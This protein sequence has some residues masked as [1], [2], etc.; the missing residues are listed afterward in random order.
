MQNLDGE[1]PEEA[2]VYAPLLEARYK[3]IVQLIH[4]TG[5]DQVLELASGFSMRGLAM[6]AASGMTYLESDLP[7]I[8]EE[9]SKFVADLIAKHNLVGLDRHHIITANALNFSEFEAAIHILRRDRPLVVVNEGLLN[10]LSADERS[11]VA[12]NVRKLLS[13]FPGG[14]WITPDFTT[15]GVAENVSETAKR[16]RRA[17]SGITERQL[18]EAAFVDE[19]A[20][21]QFVRDSG[22]KPV[23]YYQADQVPF[24]SS[25][26]R[27]ELS[28]EIVIKMRPR[29]RTWLL[30]PQ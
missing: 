23:S 9:K 6:S 11:E 2:K 24:L 19:E 17:L 21:D 16:F 3:S 12:G 7:G 10:Y 1:L 30:S 22:F 8:S 18:N 20:I 15:R 25:L 27:L 28:P 13:N 5:M 26:K 29:M 14:A 4:K